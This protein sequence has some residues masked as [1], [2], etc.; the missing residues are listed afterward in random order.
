MESHQD[1]NVDFVYEANRP[2]FVSSLL[3]CALA[4]YADSPVMCAMMPTEYI[5]NIV[6]CNF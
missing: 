5:S 4:N 6:D 2:L 3:Y 1:M